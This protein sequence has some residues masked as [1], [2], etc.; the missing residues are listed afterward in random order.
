MATSDYPKDWVRRMVSNRGVNP[1]AKKR[2]PALY[3]CGFTSGYSAHGIQKGVLSALLVAN[4]CRQK[5]PE[6]FRQFARDNFS[7]DRPNG[8]VMPEQCVFGF[9]VAHLRL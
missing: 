4:L 5:S 2:W 8:S 7:T 3:G 9:L 1:P 6:L